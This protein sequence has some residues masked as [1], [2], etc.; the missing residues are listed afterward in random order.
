MGGC[1]FSMYQRVLTAMWYQQL[2]DTAEVRSGRLRGIQSGCMTFCLS[3]GCKGSAPGPVV[4]T[5]TKGKY[6][7]VPFQLAAG[8][9]LAQGHAFMAA[10]PNLPG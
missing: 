3:E 5:A 8:T 1:P 10:M 7:R 6:S 2:E 4:V 9:E